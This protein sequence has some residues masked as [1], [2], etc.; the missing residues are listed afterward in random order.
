MPLN[1]SPLVIDLID[2]TAIKLTTSTLVGQAGESTITTRRTAH[3][4]RE[5][6]RNR[7]L[8]LEVLVASAIPEQ[9]AAY[10]AEVTAR[11]RFRV[12]DAYPKDKVEM[13]VNVNGASIL[14]G[15]IREMLTNLTA[16]CPHGA[17]LLPSVSF[18]PDG[19]SAPENKEGA[20]S[21]KPMARIGKT[22]PSS[23]R[24]K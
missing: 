14:Y 20:A 3:V 2:F 19:G 16:R 12:H 13:L 21:P 9:P 15:A 7:M 8:E 6:F 11:G 18:V 1:P 4:H 23:K 22:A 24:S 5:H 10:H 17:F